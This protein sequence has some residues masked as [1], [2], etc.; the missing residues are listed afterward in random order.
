[1]ASLSNTLTPQKGLIFR[2]THR[3]NVRW[4][5]Q[6]GLRCQGSG[7][8][9]PDFVAIGNPELISVRRDREVEIPPG[10]TL[11]DYVPFYFTPCSPMLLN[12]T[13]GY[14]GI[15]KRSKAEIVVLVS[16]LAAL[17][18]NGVQYVYTDRHA[19]LQAATFFDDSTRLGSVVDFG[20]LQ[21]RDFRLDPERP[22]KVERYQ[23][24]ALAY[25]YVPVSALLG[26]GCYTPAIKD[27]LEATC[28]DVGVKINVVVRTEWY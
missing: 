7:I 6:N 12:I 14:R 16:S 28:S 3:D 21:R 2:I 20:L 26:I 13:T 15:R 27:D 22:D 25:H 9:D 11:A 19:Y 17:Q 10:G 18:S 8:A 5:L 24:E 1:M 23:A 4:I